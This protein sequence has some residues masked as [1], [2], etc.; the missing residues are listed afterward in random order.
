[1]NVVGLDIDFVNRYLVLLPA[2]AVEGVPH[3]YFCPPFQDFVSV[4]GAKDD[5]I[6]AQPYTVRQPFVLRLHSFSS[7]SGLKLCYFTI[8]VEP[9]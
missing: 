4:F 3:E 9:S 1:M 7:P 8:P 6:L 5:M 2:Q